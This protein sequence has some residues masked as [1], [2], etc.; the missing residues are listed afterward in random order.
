MIESR[1]VF[2]IFVSSTFT[3]LKA[4][5]ETLQQRVFPRLRELCQK[6]GARL[7]AIDLRWGISEEASLDQKTMPICLGEI[8]RCQAITPKPN[9]IVLLGDRYGWRPPPA[10]IEAREFEELLAHF[11]PSEKALVERWYRRDDNAVPPE[12]LLQPRTK[13][14]E[15]EDPETWSPVEKKVRRSLAD[16]AQAAGFGAARLLPYQT[17]ATHQEILAGALGIPDAADHVFCF[18]R[19]LTGEPTGGQGGEF[20]DLLEDGRPD[21]EARERLEGLKRQLRRALPGNVNEYEA[22]WNPSG[23]STDHLDR[24]AEEVYRSLSSVIRS[25]IGSLEAQD[26]L[27]LEVKRQ[28]A[29]AE[30]R[31][32]SFCGRAKILSRIAEYIAGSEPHALGLWGESGSGKSSLMASAALQARRDHPESIVICRFLGATPDSSSGRTLLRS[33]FGQ[34]ARELEESPGI[35]PD[36]F[37]ELV[38]SLP[39]WLASATAAR[40]IILFLDGLDHLSV[41]DPAR[42]LI[43]L[44]AE[45][46]DH[47][48]V[49]VSSLPGECLSSLQAKLPTSALVEVGPMA[50]SE[51]AEILD[52]GLTEA[53]RTLTP[54]QRDRILTAFQANGLPLFLR[55]AT[56]EAVGWT[57]YNEDLRLEDTV[58]GMI[59]ALFAR[60]SDDTN[61]GSALVHR[62]LGF[63][64]A[65][66]RGLAEDEL[67]DL[68]ST[69]SDVMDDFRKRAVRSPV[70]Q[71]L[72]V[73]VWSRFFL[74]L[75][76]YLALKPV[77]GVNVLEFFHRTSFGKVVAEEIMKTE[78]PELHR[79]LARYYAEQPNRRR[80]EGEPQPSLRKFTEL[81][82]QLVRGGLWEEL[83]ET[84]SDLDFLQAKTEATGPWSLDEDFEEALRTGCPH[85][86]LGMIQDVVRLSASVLLLRPAELPGQLL[87]RL[88]EGA[89]AEVEGLRDQARSWIGNPWL[90]P[91]L[92]SLAP[93]GGPFIRALAG[94]T[95]WIRSIAVTADGRKA[96]SGA[97]DWTVRIWD[98]EDGEELLA[99]EG[100]QGPVLGVACITGGPLVVS[101]SQDGTLRVW[102]LA[103]GS[104]EATLDCGGDPQTAVAVTAGGERMISGSARGV[105]RVWETGSWTQTN[106]V[107]LHKSRING[108]TPSA[109]GRSVLAASSTGTITVLD[110]ETEAAD[111]T[112]GAHENKALA[113]ASLP[114]GDIVVS[115]GADNQVRVW[116]L[117]EGRETRTLKGHGDWV[118]DV[119]VI[120]GLTRV[121]SA[122]D[123]RTLRVWDLKTGAALGEFSGHTAAVGCVTVSPDGRRVLSGSGD[124]TIRLWDPARTGVGNRILGHPEWGVTAL[125][126]APDGQIGI[127]GSND[128]TLK[129][130]DLGSGEEIRTLK[131]HRGGVQGVALT[132]DGA[133]AVSASHDKTLLVWDLRNGALVRT[134]SGHRGWVNAVALTP[135]GSIAVSASHDESLSVWDPRSGRE[136]R[137][138]YSHG[139]DVTDV[140]LSPDGRQAISSSFDGSVIL[141]DLDRGR[142]LQRFWGHVGGI[143]TAA[144]SPDGRLGVSGGEDGT[145]RIW[146]LATGEAVRILNG[147]QG[148]VWTVSTTPDGAYLVSGGA[149]STVRIW[150]LATGE[151]VAVFTGDS[152]ILSSAAG[153]YG[154]KILAGEAHSRIHLLELKAP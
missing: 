104:E 70:V 127:S 13:G 150:A 105:V 139:D 82:F 153:A 149:D 21:R 2:R 43:W 65:S 29:F 3:D 25:E 66:R 8:A 4:E 32:G 81:P 7:Q 52:R 83:R 18:F 146:D 142:V 22:H 116:D 123:D 148:V 35:I 68:L 36:R 107:R 14:G 134:L 77:D 119:A 38:M 20:F 33:V 143:R 37:E 97:D 61:H 74:D 93:P 30:Q 59:R 62:T 27:D 72:P 86:D 91:H 92:P 6:H 44:P 88:P 11:T 73:V 64:A 141:W 57:S 129:V 54:S 133:M 58:D 1:N 42:K 55:M 102:N 15:Y 130:W 84:L 128:R 69:D 152:P 111:R 10:R 26:P 151:P 41:V 108:I 113:V 75:E 131:G 87:G 80:G 103:K 117:G 71:R 53:G 95:D 109:D 106:Q 19:S 48:R 78:G 101:A 136:I 31:A 51:G 24:L 124:H 79:V 112:L 16:A 110:L 90:C 47:V 9:F 126:L 140:A 132:D 56:N 138:L 96:V 23:I 85:G 135:D 12:Y 28:E 40:P 118:R 98:L 125:A 122:S 121:V 50:S 137:A 17:S 67:L 34:L 60:L 115:G 63:L 147:H 154:S 114:R 46:P 100:H 94:H 89:S 76:P 5:R 45:L 39:A 49:V 145:V 144:I 120:P 99:L